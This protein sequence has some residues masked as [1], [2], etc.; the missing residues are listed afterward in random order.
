MENNPGKN[1]TIF[2]YLLVIFLAVF[3]GTS[4]FL[5]FA[6]KKPVVE[7]A[8]VSTSLAIPTVKPTEGSLSFKQEN[9]ALLSAG[10]NLVIDLMADSNGK[11]IT[12][13]DLALS[14]DPLAFE[15]VNAES[16]LTDFK[17][18]TYKR[19][20]YL[21]FLA[22][23]SP[24]NQTSAVFIQTKIA[25]LVFKPIKVGKFIFSLKSLIGKDKTDL[26]TDKTEILI[27]T[28][29]QITINVK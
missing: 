12:G 20:N 13:Y 17:I 25:S 8:A 1:K 14:Y 6:N 26:V 21:S 5:I 11:N 10:N 22:T 19:D 18:Y 4:V 23:K 16:S 27:P 29:N 7:K 24:Q 2:V 9:E 28:L 3:I 15:F